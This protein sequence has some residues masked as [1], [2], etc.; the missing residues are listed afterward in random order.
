MDLGLVGGSSV[1]NT[2]P[3]KQVVPSYPAP[4]F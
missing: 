1:V 4:N 3:L 2:E